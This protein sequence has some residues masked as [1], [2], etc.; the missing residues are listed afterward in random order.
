MDN[1]AGRM[2]NRSS[3]ASIGK[4]ARDEMF[5][6]KMPSDVQNLYCPTDKKLDLGP[7]L[8]YRCVACFALGPAPATRTTGK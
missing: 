7:K 4:F 1:R 8:K 5:Y 3:Y 6:Q 2:E